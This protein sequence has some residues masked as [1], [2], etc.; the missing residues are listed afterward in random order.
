MSQADDNS[1]LS[2]IQILAIKLPIKNANK[3]QM[4]RSITFV[5]RTEII[6]YYTTLSSHQQGNAP[7][8]TRILEKYLRMVRLGPRILT[9][10][11]VVVSLVVPGTDRGNS[12]SQAQAKGCDPKP[13]TYPK[14]SANPPLWME[15]RTWTCHPPLPFQTLRC[16]LAFLT[17]RR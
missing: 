12:P 5:T 11:V 3:S 4:D 6:K 14:H 9:A 16:I 13:L 2:Y 8:M 10:L 17:F 15:I 1:Q 7:T